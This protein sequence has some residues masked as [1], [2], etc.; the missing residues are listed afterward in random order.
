MPDQPTAPLPGPQT[1]PATAPPAQPQTQAQPAQAQTAQINYSAFDS[2]PSGGNTGKYALIFGAVAVVFLI[3]TMIGISLSSSAGPDASLPNWFGFGFMFIFIV[4]LLGVVLY[5]R[6]QSKIQAA[7]LARF[8]LDNGWQAIPDANGASADVATSLL[9]V[10]SQQRVSSGFQGTYMGKPF[11]MLIYQYVTGSGRSQETHYFLNLHFKLQQQFP[12]LVLDDRLNNPLKLFS[13]LPS[14]VPNGK[15]LQPE[16]DFSSRFRLTVLPGT[17]QDV[18]QV[19][20]PDFMSELMQQQAVAD[21][22]IEAGNLFVIRQTNG[23]D[24][25]SLQNMFA[26]A[27]VM[28][29][30]LA[31]LSPTWQASSSPAAVEQMAETALQPRA[32]LLLKHRK[33]ISIVSIVVA[34]VYLAIFL[35]SKR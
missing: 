25:K 20:T 23:Y 8:I 33:H 7:R 14:K 21:S 1:P 24:K 22:E 19:L 12:L 2:R 29:K 35:L 4:F 31:E 27:S 3:V 15:T 28:L 17:E 11:V 6:Q 34:L 10:G 5:A 18:L 32:T 26:F 30:N 16:G 9:G 13:D